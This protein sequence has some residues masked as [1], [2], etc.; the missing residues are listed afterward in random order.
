MGCLGNLIG[1]SV[2][3][4][5]KEVC[6]GLSK[7]VWVG[8]AENPKTQGYPKAIGSTLG[9]VLQVPKQGY[10]SPKELSNT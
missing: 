10:D 2:I 9:I 6:V 3:G 7:E 4:L 5:N 8:L 1:M